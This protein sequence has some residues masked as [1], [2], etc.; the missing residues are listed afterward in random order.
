MP[1]DRM[2]APAALTRGDP[3]LCG[4]RQ[5]P[6]SARRCGAWSGRHRVLRH[7][8]GFRTGTLPWEILEAEV[9]SE[10]S[11]HHLLATCTPTWP[12]S[13]ARKVFIVSSFAGSEKSPLGPPFS[14]ARRR[15]A[16]SK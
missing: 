5:D 10:R 7:P 14:V 12:A 15:A 4:N 8:N 9:Q 3:R 2:T 1:H 16:P 13:L 11:S 6:E